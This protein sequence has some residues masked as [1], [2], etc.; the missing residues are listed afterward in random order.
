MKKNLLLP[1]IILISISYC[2]AQGL[3]YEPI[4]NLE[5]YYEGFTYKTM[6]SQEST[7]YLTRHGGLEKVDMND[8]SISYKWANYYP[9]RGIVAD[10]GNTYVYRV[11]NQDIMRFNYNTLE[12]EN[13]WHDSLQNKSITDIDVAPNGNIWAVTGG[14]YKE[15][16]IYNGIEWE[17]FPFPGYLYYGFNGINLVNDSTA[18]I[19]GIGTKFYTFQNGVYDTLFIE[20][21]YNINHWDVDNAGNLWAARG[22]NLLHINNGIPT[23]YDTTNC[24]I[25]SDEFLIVEI[26]SNGH[27]WTCGNSNKLLEFDGTTWQ[28]HTLPVN[29]PD[30]ENFTLD[31]QNNPWVI[32]HHYQARQLYTLS[33]NNWITNDILF[34]PLRDVKAIGLKTRANASK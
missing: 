8:F 34:M 10:T 14:F 17:E 16:A 31:S 1:L 19:L 20:N 29:Y 11:D 22:E 7:L 23:I 25:G 30:I 9:V 33:G 13:I 32:V 12:Y 21:G 3:L 26:G 18:Y 15:V 27:V 2:K 4:N 28:V 24:P 6:L 5:Y